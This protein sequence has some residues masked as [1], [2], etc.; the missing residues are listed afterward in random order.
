MKPIPQPTEFSRRVGD[1]LFRCG[2]RVQLE[3]S[4]GNPLEFAEPFDVQVIN[5]SLDVLVTNANVDVQL[6]DESGN[7]IGEDNP[8]MGRIGLVSLSPA[9]GTKTVA[10]AGTA[11]PLVADPTPA[12]MLCVRALPDNTGRIYFGASDVDP[13]T[14]QQIILSASEQVS[15]GAPSGYVLDVASFYIDADVDG[16]GVGFLYMA[17]T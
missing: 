4:D 11:E 7:L 16:E 2:N 1:E 6:C 13:V 17:A 10:S 5:D 14:S 12:F 8:L 9:G 3:D 15:I